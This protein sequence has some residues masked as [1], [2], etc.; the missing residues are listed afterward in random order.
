MND[1]RAH[2]VIVGAGITGLTAAHRLLNPLDGSSPLSR[3]TVIE[4]SSHIGGKIRTSSFAGVDGVD[5]GPDSYLARVPAAGRLSRE[6]G[7]ADALTNPTAAHASVMHGGLHRIPDGLMMG[8][9]T[10]ALSLARSNLLSWRGKVRAALEPILPSS[11]D[12]RDSVGNFVRQRFGREVHELLVDPLVGG[13][14]AADTANFSLATVPQ[15]ADLAHGRSVLLTARRRRAAAVA[16]GPVFETPR[17]GLG[18]LTAALAAS[19]E[20]CGGTII[21]DTTVSS[22]RRTGSTYSIDTDSTDTGSTTIDADFVIVTS[23]AAVSA[24][25]LRPLSAELSDL[26]APTEHA[27]V[28]MVTVRATGKALARFEGMSGYLVPK[29]DQKRVTA[30]SFGSNK[31]AHWR[32]DDDSMIMRVSLGRDGAPTH[33]LVHEWD[34]ERLVRQVVDEMRDHTGVDI[35]PVEHRVTRWEHS[36]P[37]Y[38]PGHL[39][40]VA[41][42]EAIVNTE[43]PGVHLAGA[44]MR[45]IGIASCITQAE[46]AA[47]SILATIDSTTRLRD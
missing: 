27:S 18:A 3:V 36:F 32:P 24:P 19:I 35:A 31:W 26:L 12:H 21:T 39:E 38:R 6:V 41:T 8:I 30:A 23:P 33:D 9:P 46:T 11:G 47:A 17:A 43:A 25:F 1:P 14:Y 22:V 45:G 29:P 10:G 2:V 13:I 42:M 7:L 34:D 44:S 37:Q 4:S 20:R 16:S 28:V 15:L 40:R 5:E